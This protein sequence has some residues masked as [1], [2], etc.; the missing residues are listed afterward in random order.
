MNQL[1][2]DALMELE[3]K[4]W[5]SLCEQTGGSFYGELMTD[6]AVMVLVNGA[7]LDKASVVQ[8]LNEAPGWDGYE[9]NDTRLVALGPDAAALVYRATAH[10]GG[11]DSFAAAMTSCYRIVDGSPRLALYTQTTA[12]H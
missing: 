7:V 2:L 11:E 1:T 12:T 4:G 8:S 3:R 9:I 10:R 5:D 6:D